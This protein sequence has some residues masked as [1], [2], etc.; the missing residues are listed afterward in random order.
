MFMCITKNNIEVQL[1]Y[2]PNSMKV[3]SQWILTAGD[4]FDSILLRN[5]IPITHMPPAH[6]TA[7]TKFKDKEVVKNWKSMN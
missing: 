4:L 3:L 5:D 1:V 2:F 6:Q 7:L